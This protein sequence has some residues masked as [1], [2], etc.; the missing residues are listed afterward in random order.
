MSFTICAFVYTYVGV[1]CL[2]LSDIFFYSICFLKLFLS[3]KI[4][5]KN[6]ITEVLKTATLRIKN[7]CPL[8]GHNAHDSYWAFLPFQTPHF[9]CLPDIFNLP[10]SFSPFQV[11]RLLVIFLF[12]PSA[13]LTLYPFKVYHSFRFEPKHHLPHIFLANTSSLIKKSSYLHISFS[14]I[15]TVLSLYLW[16]DYLLS[17]CYFLGH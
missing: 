8:N 10:V 5:G 17:L 4:P 12:L 9:L 14:S 15:I 1:E 6:C 2:V 13:S 16:Y 7:K 11:L 3:Y